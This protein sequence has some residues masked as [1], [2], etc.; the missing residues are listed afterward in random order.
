MRP[1]IAIDRDRR[2]R[3]R[4][5]RPELGRPRGRTKDKLITGPVEPD[6]DD[7]GTTIHPGIGQPRRV[8]RPQQCLR[9]RIIEQ[10]ETALL[11]HLNPSLDDRISDVRSGGVT[12]PPSTC[13]EP[14]GRALRPLPGKDPWLPSRMITRRIPRKRR[15]KVSMRRINPIEWTSGYSHSPAAEAG[16]RS[17]AAANRIPQTLGAAEDPARP[18]TPAQPGIPKGTAMIM[19]RQFSSTCLYS[20]YARGDHCR[21]RNRT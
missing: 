1:L 18:P 11:C 4:G 9:N 8:S 16:A 2:P 15:Q 3:V 10:F 21:D 13:T 14:P 19:L 17:C 20:E 5:Q 6:R 7:P 12:G